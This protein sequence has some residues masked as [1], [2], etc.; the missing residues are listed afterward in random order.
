MFS[1]VI[2]GGEWENGPRVRHWWWMREFVVRA[3]SGRD[4]RGITGSIGGLEWVRDERCGAKG[5]A[6]AARSFRS[7]GKEGGGGFYL[8]QWMRRGGS[9]DGGYGSGARGPSA[10]VRLGCG[11]EWRARWRWYS[12]T[13]KYHLLMNILILIKPNFVFFLNLEVF[14]KSKVPYCIKVITKRISVK[15]SFKVIQFNYI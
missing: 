6:V 10:T 15:S 3:L 9:D 8:W 13:F 11:S 2:S 1:C 7:H 12:I 4:E 14:Q 5:S